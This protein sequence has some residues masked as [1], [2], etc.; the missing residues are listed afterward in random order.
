MWLSVLVPTPPPQRRVGD[1]CNRHHR[2]RGLALHWCC[3]PCSILDDL[4]SATNGINPGLLPFPVNVPCHGFVRCARS[5]PG[6]IACTKLRSACRRSGAGKPSA[7]TENSV[8]SGSENAESDD[9][10]YDTD[11]YDEWRIEKSSPSRARCAPS[12]RRADIDGR[13]VSGPS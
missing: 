9:Y 8:P 2:G 7:P 11:E 10:I 12:R 5:V 4:K 6:Q 13:R 1:P 3:P